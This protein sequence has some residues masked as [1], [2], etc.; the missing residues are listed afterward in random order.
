MYTVGVQHSCILGWIC[1]AV[2]E[3]NALVVCSEWM[4][5][6]VEQ[7]SGYCVLLFRVV[8]PQ[9]P[10][11]IDQLSVVSLLHWAA[12]GHGHEANEIA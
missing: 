3:G 2:Y 9:T 8:A 12:S 1:H 6:Y 5:L 7:P 10:Q 4:L 11:L